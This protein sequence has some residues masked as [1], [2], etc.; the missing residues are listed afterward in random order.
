MK[1]DVFTLDV[2]ILL[3]LLVEPI[4]GGLWALALTPSSPSPAQDEPPPDALDKPSLAR[5][6]PLLKAGSA[7]DR[8]IGG[9]GVLAAGWQRRGWVVVAFLITLAFALALGAVFGVAIAGV[10]AAVVVLALRTRLRAG[11]V[12]WGLQAIYDVLLPWLMGMVALE[13][14]ADR[15]LAVYAPPVAAAALFAVVYLACLA[16]LANQGW[17]ALVVLDGAQLAVLGLLLY[18]KE[19]L[20]VWI[21]GLSLVAQLVVHPWFIKGGDGTGYVRRVA[22]YIILAMLAA[23]IALAL[24]TPGA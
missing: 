3:F 18:Q 12:A 8:V 7:A 20:G 10:G 16:L 4:M 24:A 19:T 15:G 6:L 9:L 2:T 1:L 11:M 21:V 17:P 22:P 23:A 13:L 5:A 14:A